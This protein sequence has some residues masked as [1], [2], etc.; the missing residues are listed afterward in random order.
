MNKE[1]VVSFSGGK[2][3]T[4]MLLLMLEKNMQIDE[5]V[6]ADTGK[7]FPEMYVHIEKVEEFTGR[8]ITRLKE[9]K[10]F[11]YWFAEHVKTK[12]SRKGEVGYGWPT[13]KIRW[14]TAALKR[15]VFNRHLR[16]RNVALYV[17]IAYD[18]KH[19]AKEHSYP[20]IDWKITEKQALEYCYAR[21]FDW[22]GL[23]ELFGRVSCWC[24]PLKNKK[25]LKNLYFHRPE[26]WNELKKM[27]A[28]SSAKFKDVGTEALE[29]EFC[30]ADF[31]I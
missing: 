16:G 14:C 10:G 8:K 24:C 17:G 15:N 9:K 1:H 30:V 12:G 22:G 5:I 18:E 23:Y 26:L 20:L 7:E 6:F 13:S 3:S 21:G 11:D 29:K 25:E 27:E 2:D 31:L 4:A 19:R 28:R